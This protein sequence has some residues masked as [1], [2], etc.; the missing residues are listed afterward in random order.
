MGDIEVDL[1]T[2][3]AALVHQGVSVKSAAVIVL[4]ALLPMAATGMSVASCSW[5]PADELV[6]KWRA[7]AGTEVLEFLPDGTVIQSDEGG[8][9]I[10]GRYSRVS[11]ETIRVSFGGPASYAPPADYRAVREADSLEV[12]DP[13]GQL[14]RYRRTD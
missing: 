9:L 10:G 7:E 2:P 12:T 6:G 14:R 3:P 8:P 13:K 1:E 11:S 5:T 4:L